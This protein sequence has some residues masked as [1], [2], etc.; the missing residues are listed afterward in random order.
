MTLTGAVVLL[1]GGLDSTVSM[2]VSLKSSDVRLAL[3]FNYGQ[4]SYEKE[5]YAVKNICDYYKIPYSVVNLEWLK[6]ITTTSLV[7]TNDRLP[8][9]TIE[10][11]DSNAEI[12]KESA[13]AVWVPNR[14]GVMLNIGA[15]FAESIDCS[16]LIFGANAEEAAT[17]PDNSLEYVNVLTDAFSYSTAN[18]VKILAPLA[19]KT[20]AEIVEE[21]IKI[22]VPLHF[23]WSCYSTEE[24]HCGR[25]ES[26]AR[27]HR[28]LKINNKLELW[29][30]ITSS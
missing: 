14:N 19:Q 5:L 23:L 11:L 17:F 6:N 7:N 18:S 2:A 22:N 3:F 28:A 25:C 27:L 13:K 4:R 26:C 15:S 21:A 24:K 30:A 8:E 20:K 16:Y 1:S 12:L 9:Y 29:E 10:Q